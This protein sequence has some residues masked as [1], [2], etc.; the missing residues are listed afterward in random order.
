MLMFV[1]SEISQIGALEREKENSNGLLTR[2]LLDTRY[3]GTLVTWVFEVHHWISSQRDETS[4]RHH[5]V[6]V[7]HLSFVYRLM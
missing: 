5:Y 3:P 1:R 6:Y 2:H 4:P 7:C